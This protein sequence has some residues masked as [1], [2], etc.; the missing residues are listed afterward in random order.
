MTSDCEIVSLTP[1]A[2]PDMF[3][4]EFD[5]R[6]QDKLTFIEFLFDN[7]KTWCRI[8]PTAEN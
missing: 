6:E 4:V 8:Y 1:L 2:E 3:V 7:K 5:H